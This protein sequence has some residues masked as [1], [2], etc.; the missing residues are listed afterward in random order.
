M[1]HIAERTPLSLP[2][3]ERKCDSRQSDHR[4]T[5]PVAVT[6][7]GTDGQGWSEDNDWNPERDTIHCRVVKEGFG[8]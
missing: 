2:V 7:T 5:Q 6:V 4:K 3:P 8:W 1:V